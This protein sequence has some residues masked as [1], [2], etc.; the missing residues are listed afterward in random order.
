V[1]KVVVKG[2]V[3]RFPYTKRGEEAAASFAKGKEGVAVKT[4]RKRAPRRTRARS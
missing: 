4:E 2:K 3:K 1:P